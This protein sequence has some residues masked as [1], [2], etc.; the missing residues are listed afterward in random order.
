MAAESPL[1]SDFLRSRPKRITALSQ[2]LGRIAE[3]DRFRLA[4]T[5]QNPHFI[6]T[7][8]RPFLSRLDAGRERN[9]RQ[10]AR[11]QVLATYWQR[12]CVK[13]TPS[14]RAPGSARRRIEVTP[15]VRAGPASRADA[16]VA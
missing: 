2:Q 8:L 7:C 16:P 1:G 4:L 3:S 12:Y 15:T 5:W 9:S 6:D 13:T 14:A 11:E 10:W